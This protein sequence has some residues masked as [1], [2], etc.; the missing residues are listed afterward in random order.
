M[1]QGETAVGIRAGALALNKAASTISRHVRAG[2]IPN[3]GTLAEPKIL[4]SE[5]RR[6]LEDNLDPMFRAEPAPS[7]EPS[8]PSFQSH[9]TK[10]AAAQAEKA[11]LDLAERK[12]ELVSRPEIEDALFTLA[13]NLRDAMSRRWRVLALELENLPA[14]AIE[15]K[16]LDADEKLLA[17]LAGHFETIAAEKAPAK[18]DDASTSALAAA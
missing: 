15:E 10:L 7:T 14:R 4:V 9:R 5:A 2:K 8:S 13:L 12:G 16:C 1:E 11:Q 3:R 6:A 17:Q 18:D